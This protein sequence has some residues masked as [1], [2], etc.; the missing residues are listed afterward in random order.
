MGFVRSWLRAW[1]VVIKSIFLKYCIWYN[2]F[3]RTF[4]L[5]DHQPSKIASV[6]V[7]NYMFLHVTF[8]ANRNKFLCTLSLKLCDENFI[9][10]LTLKIRKGESI[11]KQTSA[12]AFF[13][14]KMASSSLA[15]DV[16]FMIPQSSLDCIKLFR[17]NRE[18]IQFWYRKAQK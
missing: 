10:I 9:R 7:R 3:E 11:S 4:W 14:V 17:L 5:Y 12:S 13:S 18:Y 15:F 8:F 2:I 16:D 1:W 6:K